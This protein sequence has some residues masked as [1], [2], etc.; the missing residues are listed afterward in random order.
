MFLLF[1]SCGALG[2]K[3]TLGNSDK[4][5]PAN[6]RPAK[7][8]M[9]VQIF[10]KPKNGV[11]KAMA[12]YLDKKYPY[13][14]EIVSADDIRDLNGKYSDLNV[15]QFA[16]VWSKHYFESGSMAMHNHYSG[17]GY[18]LNFVDR[19]NGRNYPKTGKGC[20]SPMLLFNPVVNT[21]V[22]YCHKS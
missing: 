19:S 20:S 17:H 6:F 2:S 12:K 11:N 18:D 5:L 3:I 13:K 8:I 1:T 4:W 7:S 15:Y 21:I 14:Y 10:G 16:L 22:K 9:L